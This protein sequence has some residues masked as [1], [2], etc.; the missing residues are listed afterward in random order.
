MGTAAL[1][2]LE[3][4]LEVNEVRTASVTALDGSYRMAFTANDTTLSAATNVTLAAAE[5]SLV[6]A[7][8]TAQGATLPS[9]TVDGMTTF[10]TT[11]ELTTLTAD[12]VI[13]NA[14]EAVDPVND[15][16]SVTSKKVH[17]N[18][19]VAV[20]GVLNAASS[21]EILLKDKT[22]TLGVSDGLIDDSG[23]DRSGIII[24]GAPLNIPP[25]A[26]A[27]LYEHS[28]LWNQ[29]DA[30]FTVAGND[31]VP[32]RRPVFEFKGGNVA[33]SAPDT[34]SRKTTF[35]FA[36]YITA[37][38]ASLGLYQS[39]SG[40]HKLI[41]TFAAPAVPRLP[42]WVTT[43]LDDVALGEAVDVQFDATYATSYS[44][45]SGDFPDSVTLS[46]AGALAG[47]PTIAGTSN[48]IIRAFNTLANVY[49]DRQ[50][51]LTVTEPV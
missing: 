14:Y 48:F 45:L 27:A 13:S 22:V 6:G 51:S 11:P 26:D 10:N 43:T 42:V 5:V 16:L 15:T 2:I 20:S 18:G 44:K 29:Q 4:L 47:T 46:N 17:L 33:V 40:Q 49:V 34:Q 37:D 7:S 30:T 21:N 41:Q 32:H 39:M 9:V 36:P 25:E 23:N 1:T 3:G 38:V 19:D 35:F 28:L 24:P 12:M 50:F 31:I 8:F